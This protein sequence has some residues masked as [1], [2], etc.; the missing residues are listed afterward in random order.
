MTI[1]A[2]HNPTRAR[3]LA[4][5][6]T[7]VELTLALLITAMMGLSIASMMTV[8]GSATQADRDGRAVLLRAHAGQARF[9]AYMSQS[10]CV[11]QHAPERGALVIWLHDVSGQGHVNLTEFR[12]FWHDP[13]SGVVTVERVEFPEEWTDTQKEAADVVVPG[14]SDYLALIETQRALNYTVTNAMLDGA[15]SAQWTLDAQAAQQARRARLA[16]TIGP[17]PDNTQQVIFAFGVA[18]HNAPAL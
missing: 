1:T 8:V 17:T 18:E 6:M 15:W 11:L 13:V 14:D 9:G 4:R 16:V 3:R 7:L 12:V 10:R 2:A 5:A